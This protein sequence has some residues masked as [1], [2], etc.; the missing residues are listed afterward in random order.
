M[1]PWG[2]SVSFQ[3]CLTQLAGGE[4]SESSSQCYS[5]E[6]EAIDIIGLC[7][8]VFGFVLIVYA[9]QPQVLRPSMTRI[10]MGDDLFVYF[11]YAVKT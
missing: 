6:S 3:S 9:I 4:V 8:L 10:V 2:K 11:D 7:L 1:K 5:F